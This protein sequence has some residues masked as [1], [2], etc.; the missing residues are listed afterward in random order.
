M[1]DGIRNDEVEEVTYQAHEFLL[2]IDRE[3]PL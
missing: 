3:K 1:K 2:I